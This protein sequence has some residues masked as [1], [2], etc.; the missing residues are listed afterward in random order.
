MHAGWGSTGISPAHK[1]LAYAIIEMAS[2][3]KHTETMTYKA[4]LSEVSLK[5]ANGISFQWDTL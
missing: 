1:E 3:L 5:L 2:Y 4:F